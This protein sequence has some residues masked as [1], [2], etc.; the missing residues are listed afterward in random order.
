MKNENMTPLRLGMMIMLA[1]LLA[2]IL[3]FR[4][5]PANYSMPLKEAATAAADQ[6]GTAPIYFWNEIRSAGTV[7]MIV[8]IRSREAFSQEYIDGAVNIP[9]DELLDRKNLK[10]LKKSPVMIYG[11][12]EATAHQAALLLNML[13]VEAE[14]VNSSF[15]HLQ[16]TRLESGHAPAL[17]FSEEKARYNYREYFKAFDQAEPEPIEVK[18]PMPSPGGC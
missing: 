11:E 7:P 15:R 16:N 9:L 17:F 2:G 18:V 8:D 13:G 1:V 5:W 14:A 4:I 3:V 12:Q 6:Q 10:K